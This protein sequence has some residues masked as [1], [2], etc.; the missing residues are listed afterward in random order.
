M[1]IADTKNK[2]LMPILEEIRKLRAKY[3]KQYIGKELPGQL[4]CTE[5][6]ILS[7][8]YRLTEVAVKNI[9]L[10]NQEEAMENLNDSKDLFQLSFIL[11]DIGGKNGT[12]GQSKEQIKG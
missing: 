6:H 8:A 3:L 2:E 5:K 11:I 4:W 12:D 10:G 9:S 1:T 7:T